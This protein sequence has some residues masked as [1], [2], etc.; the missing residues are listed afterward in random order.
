MYEKAVKSDGLVLKSKVDAGIMSQ[1]VLGVHIYFQLS[2]L[3]VR[4][5]VGA[6]IYQLSHQ[7]VFM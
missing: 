7:N 5:H 2:N 1:R 3:D 6:I 4:V